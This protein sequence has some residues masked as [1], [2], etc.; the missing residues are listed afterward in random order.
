MQVTVI[1]EGHAATALPL[2]LTHHHSSSIAS[3]TP[4]QL[5]HCLS[6]TTTA[7][8]WSLTHHHTS[9]IFSHPPPQLFHCLLPTTTAHPLPLTHHHIS[10]IASDPPPQLFH[11]EMVQCKGWD[12]AVLGRVVYMEMTR[13]AN[14]SIRT[15]ELGSAQCTTVLVVLVVV[16]VVVLRST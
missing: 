5:F 4:P 9:S 13:L 11:C 16:E 6:P 12:Q 15:A 3:H 7:L 14:V 2:P 8:P 10:F 1:Y